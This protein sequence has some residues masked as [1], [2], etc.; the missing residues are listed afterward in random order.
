MQ[1]NNVMDHM[2]DFE[3]DNHFELIACFDNLRE[4]DAE[5]KSIHLVRHVVLIT[6]A[7]F[8]INK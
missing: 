5:R 2:H 3:F 7:K 6:N 4:V 1:L 8:S